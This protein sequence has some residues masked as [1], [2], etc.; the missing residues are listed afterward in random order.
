MSAGC[1]DQLPYLFDK[2]AWL[3]LNGVQVEA[4]AVVHFDQPTELGFVISRILCGIRAC[5]L[6]RSR[7]WSWS[8]LDRTVRQFLALAVEQWRK[9]SLVKSKGKKIQE[10]LH[11]ITRDGLIHSMSCMSALQL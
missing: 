3:T 2:G 8:F 9:T 1:Q 5:G 7:D 6:Q 10:W 4:I 11:F